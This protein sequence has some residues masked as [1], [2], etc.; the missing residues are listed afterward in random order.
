M[1]PFLQQILVP[2]AIIAAA[3]GSI[4]YGLKMQQKGLKVQGDAMTKVDES[5]AL[6]RHVIEIQ[7]ENLAVQHEIRGLLERM[8]VLQE[9]RP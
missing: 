4:I 9:R 3:I 2:L 7:E 5:I 8:V 6:Q 1:D